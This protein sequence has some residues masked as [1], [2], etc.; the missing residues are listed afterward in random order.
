MLI[1]YIIFYFIVHRGV[2]FEYFIIELVHFQFIL[3][4]KCLIL[5]QFWKKDK[6][7]EKRGARSGE[8]RGWKLKRVEDLG[9]ER[10]MR[11]IFVSFSLFLCTDVFV[12]YLFVHTCG[13][14]LFLLQS[15]PKVCIFIS[16]EL[17]VITLLCWLLFV[18]ICR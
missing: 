4:G 3:R 17:F 18:S 6:V 8:W 15:L 16:F 13:G 11:L 2:L 5:I 7:C 14:V 12:C 1:L 10:C 9:R